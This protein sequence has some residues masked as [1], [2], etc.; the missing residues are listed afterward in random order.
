MLQLLSKHRL[1]ITILLVTILLAVLIQLSLPMAVYAS[2]YGTST[3]VTCTPNP[4]DQ[5]G[6]V[7][8]TA[9][10]G[11][12]TTES[13]AVTPTGKVTWTQKSQTADPEI[14]GFK[15]T[16]CT[17]IGLGGSTVYSGDSA[18]CSVRVICNG[19]GVTTITAEYSYAPSSAGYEFKGSKGTFKLTV[20]GLQ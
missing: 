17:L 4:A 9:W 13:G 6:I 20:Y 19:Y 3:Q 1:P 14:V 8:C 2:A 7:T 15:S 10:V 16:S 11:D 18:S 5:S 12:T